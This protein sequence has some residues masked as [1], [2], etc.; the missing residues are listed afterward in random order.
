MKH[1]D[2]FYQ[3]EGFED[4]EH[5]VAEGDTSLAEIRDAVAK[6]HGLDATVLVFLEDDDEVIITGFA[7]AKDYRVGFGEV[8]GRVIGARVI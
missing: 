4:I 6:K 8:R 2:V 3:R 5:I 7:Q 1:V